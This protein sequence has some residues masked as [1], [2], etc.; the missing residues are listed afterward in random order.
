MTTPYQR[1]R[2]LVLTKEFLHRLCSLGDDVLPLTMVTE[3]EAL[4]RHFPTLRDIEAAHKELP[5][6]FGPVPPF[7]RVIQNPEIL[8]ILD[9]T[10]QAGDR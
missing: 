5:E 7:Q 9:A 6:V 2:S 3:A 10:S 8:G 4:L 1:T